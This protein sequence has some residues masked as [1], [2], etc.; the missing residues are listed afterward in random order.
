MLENAERQVPVLE[1]V[2]GGDSEDLLLRL[3]ESR[4]YLLG[5]DPDEQ[6]TRGIVAV[7]TH[8]LS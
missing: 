1:A 7:R 5:P 6:L 8:K 2:L 4:D 3:V